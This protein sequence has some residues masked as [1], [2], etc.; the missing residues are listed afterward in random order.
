MGVPARSMWTQ[1]ASERPARLAHAACHVLQANQAMGLL[2]LMK[3]QLKAVRG[4]SAA[5]LARNGPPAALALQVAEQLGLEERMLLLHRSMADVQG[6]PIRG[7]FALKSP[8]G[9]RGGGELQSSL[10]QHGLKDSVAG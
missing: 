9:V 5:M 3:E 4:A 1:S 10:Q 7:A 6:S 2:A 8:V